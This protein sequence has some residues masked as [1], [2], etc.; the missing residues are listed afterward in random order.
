VCQLQPAMHL[1]LRT[2]HALFS[3]VAI[4]NMRSMMQAST[5]PAMRPFGGPGTLRPTL[6][7]SRH[8]GFR[9]ATGSA[10]EAMRHQHH[11][12]QHLVIC[13]TAAAMR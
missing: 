12:I 3:Q 13:A 2:L 6:L 11:C 1:R 7:P 9:W 10:A 4:A 5:C 8:R